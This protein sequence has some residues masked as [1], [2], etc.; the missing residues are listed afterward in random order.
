MKWNNSWIL[1][2][3]SAYN[4][5]PRMLARNVNILVESTISLKTSVDLYHLWFRRFSNWIMVIPIIFLYYTRIPNTY[6]STNI[7]AF[8][9]RNGKIIKRW[10]P[11]ENDENLKR[12][13]ASWNSNYLSRDQARF[14][15]YDT[16]FL[17]SLIRQELLLYFFLHR[18]ILKI[19]NKFK[20]FYI[21]SGLRLDF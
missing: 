21:A 1:Y 20:S 3:S 18:S 7:R 13:S 10:I 19:E 16:T 6:L 5:F 9:I 12:F 15:F 17:P 4:L 11:N 8:T 2:L 14:L